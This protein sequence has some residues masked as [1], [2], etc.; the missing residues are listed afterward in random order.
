MLSLPLPPE[1]WRII[2]GFTVEISGSIC[3]TTEYCPFQGVQELA[4]CSEEHYAQRL[5][6]CVLLVT[7]CKSWQILA[8]G[9]FYH[10][11]RLQSC[12]HLP[13]L[14]HGLRRIDGEGECFGRYVRRLE[15]HT[16]SSGSPSCLPLSEILQLCPRLEIL[17]RPCPERWDRISCSLPFLKRLE[18]TETDSNR[19]D[20]PSRLS[21]IL[22]AAPNMR[23]LALTSDRPDVLAEISLAPALQTLVLHQSELAT[24]PAVSSAY[25][26]SRI[27]TLVLHS[28][29]S[30]A[31]VS[32]ITPLG[33]HLKVLEFAFAPHVAYSSSQMN[34]LLS[35]CPNIEELVYHLGAPEIASL[36]SHLQLPRIRQVRLRID[37][38]TWF[39]YKHVVLAQ[40]QIL[41]GSPFPGLRTIFLHD[42]SRSFVRRS[43]APKILQL[44]KERGLAVVYENG[45]PVDLV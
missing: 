17:V 27:T 9:L 8:A 26:S 16:T 43:S 1:I 22:K 21:G 13:D 15:F 37:P 24:S 29:I 32:F 2:F 10:D 42:T 11:I 3:Y 41:A 30:P 40:F 12:R 33:R 39:P 44:M 20:I 19:S 18:W 38:E 14:F 4:A 28:V 31:L 36:P 34:K 25:I 35:H 45:C 5:K 7:V 6:T 23:Y